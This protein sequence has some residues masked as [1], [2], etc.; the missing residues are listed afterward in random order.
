MDS[1]AL[2]AI[3]WGTTSARAYRL[4]RDGATLGETSAPLGIQQVK[5]GAFAPALAT[6]LGEWRG[7]HL[8]RIACGMIGSR[9]GWAE[10]PYRS[11][12]AAL[13]SL[14]SALIGTPGG[15]LRIVPGVS[16]RDAT[17]VPDVMRGEETQILGTLAAAT[18]LDC[19]RR[20]IVLPGT[21]SKWA[22]VDRATIETFATFMTGE[23]FAV[24]RDHSI[25]G[26]MMADEADAADRTEGFRR[27]VAHALEKHRSEDSLLH[28]L[29]G[30]RTLALCGELA[31][32]ASAEYLSG[33]LV[34]N[35]I[36]AGLAWSARHCGP[37]LPVTVIGARALG[38]RYRVAFA[39]AGVSAHEGPADAAA[40]GLWLIAQRAGLVTS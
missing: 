38:E 6:L 19:T 10:A 4:A 18:G 35:E 40:R 14:A 9:Q 30:A 13:D 17:R 24:L 32:G 11:C 3:D 7:E 23:V 27:G 26:R 36:G 1:A 31:P 33:L 5:D 15:E 28:E 21:H 2:I 37:N 20:L 12:P 39:A 8:P 34:G 22:I 29:F 25:L 16:C